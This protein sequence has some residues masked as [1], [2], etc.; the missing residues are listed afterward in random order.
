MPVLRQ[1][2][3]EVGN[4]TAI[5]MADTRAPALQP[6]NVTLWDLVNDWASSSR[7]VYSNHLQF[8]AQSDLKRNRHWQMLKQNVPW[9]IF[10]PYL[11]A[12]DGLVYRTME[13]IFQTN[14]LVMGLLVAEVGAGPCCNGGRVGHCGSWLPV[15]LCACLG[16]A[17]QL[18]AGAT[19]PAHSVAPQP[20]APHVVDP[21]CMLSRTT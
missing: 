15:Q 16:A 21:H 17:H 3:F 18:G 9:N 7:E 10:T 19:P 8:A 14:K 4:L 6:I 20:A 5:Y 1:N 12:M 13:Q 11:G 2:L